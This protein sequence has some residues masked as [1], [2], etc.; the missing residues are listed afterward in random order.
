MQET[1]EKKGMIEN[2]IH[3]QIENGEFRSNRK[4]NEFTIIDGEK[5]LIHVGNGEHTIVDTDL[6]E[7]LVL[8]SCWSETPQGYIRGGV[9]GVGIR[10]IHEIVMR[11]KLRKYGGFKEDTGLRIVVNHKDGNPKN[12]RRSNLEVITQKENL[13]KGDLSRTKRAKSGVKGIRWYTQLN[14]YRVSISNEHVGY[15]PTLDEAIEARNHALK[16]E[17]QRLEKMRLDW[18]KENNRI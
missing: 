14:Q 10:G 1:I 16:A 18:M 4:F 12:N 11:H 2:V 9:K 3:E 15:Y 5:S 17:F 8:M 7:E 13:L 6:L